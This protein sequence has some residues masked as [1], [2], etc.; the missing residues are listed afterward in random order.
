MAARGRELLRI[1]KCSVLGKPGLRETLTL[2]L[3]KMVPD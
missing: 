3:L 2:N 1:I